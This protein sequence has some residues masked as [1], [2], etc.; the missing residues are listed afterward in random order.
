MNSFSVLTGSDRLDAEQVGAGAKDADRGEIPVRVDDLLQ[1]RDVHELRRCT[2]QQRVAVGL[3]PRH[4]D[5]ADR[6]AAAGPVL[7][8][9]RL[10]ELAREILRRQPRHHVG[11]AAGGV[12]YDDRDGTDRPFGGGVRWSGSGGKCCGAKAETD[13]ASAD[14]S[15][16]SSG[17]LHGHDAIR[18]WFQRNSNVSHHALAFMEANDAIVSTMARQAVLKGAPNAP[19]IQRFADQSCSREPDR[20]VGAGVV[21]RRDLRAG[22]SARS[23]VSA[24]GYAARLTGAGTGRCPKRA[25]RGFLP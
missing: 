13:G 2:E 18:C 24:L 23:I 11:V 15:G 5:R 9:E 22:S 17:G 8:H 10:A 16:E 25:A 12:R 7:D 4:A 1:H 14:R 19:K 20:A 6:A 3:S 21:R